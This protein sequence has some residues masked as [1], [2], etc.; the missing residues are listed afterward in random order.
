MR[1]IILEYLDQ[2]PKFQGATNVKTETSHFIVNGLY[3]KGL[4]WFVNGPAEQLPFTYSNHNIYAD[5]ILSLNIQCPVGWGS[6]IR[7]LHL[8]RGIRSSFNG[9]TYWPW[10]ATR[11]ALGWNPGDWGVIDSATEWSI[12]CNTPFWP[13]VGLVVGWIG[14][15]RSIG[16]SCQALP[17]ICFIPIVLLNM[18]L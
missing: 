13:L 3:L 12:V 15:I 7:R 14:P 2:P 6:R 8:S 10:V 1:W 5:E 17:P 18:H 9:A 11:K 16:W 4:L